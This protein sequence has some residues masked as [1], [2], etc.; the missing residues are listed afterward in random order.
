MTKRNS[1]QIVNLQFR[2]GPLFWDGRAKTLE[3]LVLMPIQ[4]PVEMGMDLEELV[5]RVHADETYPRLFDEAFGDPGIDVDRISRALAQFV[6]SLVSVDSKFDAGLREVKGVALDFPN[7]SASENR[8]KKVFFGVGWGGN[9]G[10]CASCHLQERRL[11]RR[12][13]AMGLRPWT[14]RFCRAHGLGATAWISAGSLTTR[15]VE[16]SPAWPWTGAGSERPRC[17]TS[18]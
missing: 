5:A 11:E 1:M 16:Q 14:R 17:G 7:F 2:D 12:S 18:S 13:A 8:G 9:R 3:E 6:R 4:D 15:A 10:S